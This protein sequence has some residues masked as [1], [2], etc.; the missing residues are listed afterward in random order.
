MNWSYACKLARIMLGSIALAGL[1]LAQEPD[2][3][4]ANKPD[5]NPG[6]QQSTPQNATATKDDTVTLANIRKAVIDDKSLST[7]AHNVKI[8][9]KYGRV[10]LRGPVRSMAEKAR[11]E[12]LAKANGA[13]SVTNELEA[14]PESL[15]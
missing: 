9:V 6:S 13:S 1:T 4:K 2:N 3:S 7:Y 14:V 8:T 5:R 11:I 15:K 12:E 10:T